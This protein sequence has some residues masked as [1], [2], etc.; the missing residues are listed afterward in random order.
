M[1]NLIERYI[2]DVTRRL[3][4]KEREDVKRELNSNIYDMLS[5]D[6][7][8]KE[9]KDVLYD[10]GSPALLAEKY[11]QKPRYLISPAIYDDYVHALK[12]ILPMVGG[13]LLALGMVLG[14]LDALNA[15]TV[16]QS[17]VISALF[18]NGISM[19]IS[20]A[21]QA[22][23]WVTVAFAIADRIKSKDNWKVE[24]LPQTLPNN[25]NV[26]PLSDSIAELILTIVFG[27][28]SLLFCS[29]IIPMNVIFIMGKVEVN[30][31]FSDSFL[32]ACIPVI[33]IA[34]ILQVVESIIKIKIRQ[35]TPVSCGAVV[36]NNLIGI[37]IMFYLINQPN[38]LS[39]QFTN[40]I[41]NSEFGNFELL[42]ILGNSIENPIII[43]FA[44]IV[45]TASLMECVT[46][47]FRTI[48][49]S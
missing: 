31:L 39:S 34:V 10:L 14:T 47:I 32:L 40:F 9:I 48:K 6:A 29:K 35:W 1:S 21:I 42:R 4:E 38:I 26:I 8:E 46:S 23:V 36:I 43:V 33:I 30:Q 25:K 11:R 15:D 45:I 37:G 24:D 3:P 41:N 12:W 5:E 20:G 44:I 7:S 16:N 17:T 18:S 27:I 2:Y 28:I 19:G 22:L 13:I 49:A